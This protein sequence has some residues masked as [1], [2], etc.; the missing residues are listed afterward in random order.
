MDNVKKKATKK[1][2]ISYKDAQQYLYLKL[3]MDDKRAFAQYCAIRKVEIDLTETMDLFSF[4]GEN[5]IVTLSD[6]T[7]FMME[8]EPKML[9]IFD[10]AVNTVYPEKK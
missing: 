5:H 2:T 1:N 4:G 6:F 3:L 10:N 8:K 7:R 9:E